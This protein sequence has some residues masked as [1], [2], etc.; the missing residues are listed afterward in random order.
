M[1]GAMLAS[2]AMLR[3]EGISQVPRCTCSRARHH[4]RRP[5]KTN[6]VFLIRGSR[7]FA[8]VPPCLS[9]ARARVRAT[10]PPLLPS[11][12][13]AVKDASRGLRG[14]AAAGG[15][16]AD[17]PAPSRADADARRRLAAAARRLRWC[18]RSAAGP[19]GA[20][21][22]S[23]DGAR[24]AER[25]YLW[26]RDAATGA[27]RRRDWPAI[28]DSA[29]ESAGEC[30]AW[31]FTDIEYAHVAS[32]IEPAD[33]FRFD[34]ERTRALFALVRAL[35]TNFTVVA[36]RW[37]VQLTDAAGDCPSALE[38]YRHFCSHV[39][40][41]AQLRALALGEAFHEDD[42]SRSLQS[43]T[44]PARDVAGER[45]GGPG[46]RV[47]ATVALALVREHPVARAA[48]TFVTSAAALRERAAHLDAA[49]AAIASEHV[50]DSALRARA[51]TVQ[52]EIASLVDKLLAA[53]A[54]S[55]GAASAPSA[56]APRPLTAASAS[57]SDAAAA[58]AAADP[59]P[60]LAEAGRA[61]AAV[62]AFAEA[63][64]HFSFAP[65]SVR[66]AIDDAV[67]LD[68]PATSARPYIELEETL[69]RTLMPL[70]PAPDRAIS[71]RVDA[72]RAT[73]AATA[74]LD[75]E[76]ARVRSRAAAMRAAAEAA[77]Q[78]ALDVDVGVVLRDR[79]RQRPLGGE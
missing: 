22:E 38:C 75:R 54:A 5:S 58:A 57:P 15:G 36:D 2:H 70:V 64:R 77:R 43:A 1:C 27:W 37:P 12:M 66:S 67:F 30:C 20:A 63:R 33:G 65:G 25:P 62:F 32:H 76:A 18:G 60:A 61:A 29:A 59:G 17:V 4:V 3:R 48:P 34:L 44:A 46:L 10:S 21:V 73:L 8:I 51:A 74:A 69:E 26:Q 56:A 42:A 35:G 72:L 13:P 40:G 6:N 47:V 50:A 11:N 49:A 23:A 7:F 39:R 79:R 31:S 14:G 28:D 68:V 19:R 45:G 41:L 24:T 52:G 71:A 55:G 9:H 16:D 78:L 53:A